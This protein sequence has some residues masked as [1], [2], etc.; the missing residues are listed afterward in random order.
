MSNHREIR[1]G[2]EI[3]CPKCGKRWDVNDRYPPKCVEP[4]KVNGLRQI[5]KLRGK[6]GL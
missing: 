6:F 3:F 2:D 5:A 4:R 1:E